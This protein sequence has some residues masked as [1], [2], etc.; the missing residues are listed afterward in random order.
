HGDYGGDYGKLL[1]VGIR[2]ATPDDPLLQEDL[3]ACRR[4][5]VGGV[6]LFDVD[7]PTL[8]RLPH[9]DPLA[10]PRNIHSEEQLRELIALIR[11]QLGPDTW[12]SLD[13]EGGKVARLCPRRGFDAEPSAVEFAAMAPE[14]RVDTARKQAQQ[15][16]DLGFNLNFAPCVDL[17]LNPDNPIIAARGRSFSANPE[18][19]IEA[20][21]V[22]L[23]AH[24][25][26]GVAACLKHFPGH[27]SS[28]ADTHLG[29]VDITNAWQREQEL[30]PYRELCTGHGVA[31]M[32]AHVIHRELD[33]EHPA[34][35]SPQII[36]GLLRNEL[37]YNGVVITD[38]IDM[39]AI[40]DHFTPGQA[41]VAAIAAGADL[42]VDGFNLTEREAHPAQEL[43]AALEAAIPESR[44]QTSLERIARLRVRSAAPLD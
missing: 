24:A 36:D 42:V 2:G 30:A 43:V 34:S 28:D 3:Q 7:A 8:A 11:D 35:L 38:S 6:I 19:V 16:A 13:Q 4:A 17:A 37:G 23:A 39:R 5:A 9:A 12:I 29:A 14:L 26:A 41:A 33:D 20:A 21:R 1:I 18:A 32:V 27:G 40:A 22:V 15:L 44:L 25:K 10:A 31:V